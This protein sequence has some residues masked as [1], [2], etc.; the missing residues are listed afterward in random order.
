M[1]V[2]LA[3]RV[4]GVASP[5]AGGRHQQ[6]KRRRPPME[7]VHSHPVKAAWPWSCL[8]LLPFPAV[9][10]HRTRGEGPR[11]GCVWGPAAHTVQLSQPLPLL[12]VSSGLS[13]LVLRTPVGAPRSV[14]QR[15]ACSWQPSMPQCVLRVLPA[16]PSC[17]QS[18]RPA[19]SSSR[20]P[21]RLWQ[22]QT[23]QS[24]LRL[25]RPSPPSC[26]LVPAQHHSQGL[27]QAGLAQQRGQYN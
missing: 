13:V 22:Q 18:H 14:L 8:G 2:A 24:P 3:W 1:A 12:L 17:P 9:A 25:H 15:Q 23:Q 16:H 5:V 6:L 7:I 20:L 27:W 11:N 26:P 10:A 19:H 4:R 21:A